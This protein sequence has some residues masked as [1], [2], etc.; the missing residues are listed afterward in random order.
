MTEEM[1]TWTVIGLAFL[2]IAAALTAFLRTPR[3]RRYRGVPPVSLDEQ[4]KRY[5]VSA[6][7][8][9]IKGNKIRAIVKSAPYI[10]IGIVLVGF[11][12]WNKNTSNP[13][14]VRL[15]GLNTTYIWLLLFCYGLPIGLLVVSLLFVRTGMKTTRTGYFPP[16]DS[17]VF[18]DTIAKKGLVSTTRGVM[19]LVS[20]IFAVFLVYLGNDAYTQVAGRKNMHEIVEKIEAKCQ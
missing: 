10:F 15:L 7:A 1:I 2:G 5:P 17:V 16:L 13:E 14:C 6:E 11:A 9:I 8:V 20:P 4:M 12:L 19:L 3:E 18:R